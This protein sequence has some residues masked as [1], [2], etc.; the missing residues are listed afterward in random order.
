MSG[1]T[2]GL[3]SFAFSAATS[4]RTGAL[5][6]LGK[7]IPVTQF[8]DLLSASLVYAGPS[9]GTNSVGLLVNAEA[10]QAWTASSG[11][12]WLR[13]GVTNGT[14][15]ATVSFTFD[16][17]PGGVRIGTLTIAGQTLTLIQEALSL[18]VTNRVEGPAAGTDSV[19]LAS[20]D[21]PWTATANAPWLHLSPANQSGTGSTNVIFSFDANSG[22]TRVGTLTIAGLT[23]TVTQGGST[24]VRVPLQLTSLISSGLSGPYGVAVDGG[25]D[26]YIGDYYN[27]AVKEWLPGNGSVVTLPLSAVTGPIGVAV[28]AAG[29]IYLADSGTNAIEEWMP[30]NNTTVALVTNGLNGPFGVA[31]DNVGNVYIADTYNNAIKEWS[32]FS[33]AV[34]LLATN[35]LNTP[36]GIALDAAGNVYIADTGNNAIEEWSSANG[37]FTTLVS[38]GLNGPDAV[39]VDGGGNVY[40]ASSGDNTLKEWSFASGTVTT[41]VSSGLN[42]PSGVAVDAAGNVYIADTSDSATKEVVRAF[43]DPTTRLETTNAGSDVLPMILPASE[44]LLAPFA[45][46]SEQSWLTITGVTNGVVGFAFTA[47]AT[48][49]TAQISVLGQSITVNQFNDLL[50]SNLIYVGPAAGTNS[51]ALTV[52]PIAP[53]NWTAASQA[54]WLR[55]GVTNGTGGATVSFTFDANPGGVRIGTLTI[56]GQT[57]TLIQEA[58]SLGVTNRVEG[59]AAGTDSVV[60]ASLD[61]PWTATANAPWL[62]LSPANQS[63]T[64]STNVIFSFDANSGA[65]RVGTLTIAGLTL[66]VTQGGS[67]YV[68][69]PLQL[70]SLISS[71]LSGPYGVA[72]DGGGDVYIGDYYNN[73]V[74]EWLPGN[75]SVVTLPLSAVTG[76]IGVAV[77][78]AGDIYLADSGTNA[79]EEWMPSNNTTMALVTNGLNGPF[80]VAVDNVGNVYI[81]DTYNNAIKEWSPFSGAVTLLATNGLNTPEG[82][83]LDAAGNVYIADTGNN[84][85]E[86]WSSA[87]GSFTTLVSS[88]LNGP[89]AVAVDGGG[90]VY[91]ASSGDNT[92]KEWSFASG[93]VTTLVSS[94]L[95]NPS[96][97]AVDAAGNVYLGDSG[98]NAVKELPYALLDPTPKRKGT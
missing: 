14:G 35:G 59:P 45:P 43:V 96:G 97:V 89:D 17:N 90:N 56:A 13:L 61:T 57:L 33:G 40:I 84:A 44:D 28:D 2:N 68:R 25:G 23:L 24:Y 7:T 47:T 16:A 1:I 73:A 80:G 81:A 75:G 32:P 98:D 77:D 29:D 3:V 49:R 19:V 82:I 74:K 92:L 8:S 18:G 91:I 37:S 72:V 34:T 93:T 65:T 67:T 38:S 69:V 5:S 9:G 10:A 64:G 42:N 41:L 70:T 54:T 66:T 6:L 85:I 11:A 55:L 48:N 60:L 20:L 62:H 71:G 53:Q 58:L 51:V 31:V 87:N 30:S 4:N 15:G 95:N 78:A 83:A 88:G 63:G 39:A 94:G 21:T 26:V 86:E 27:N 50:N 79:I 12:P 46:A 76:P 36:E 22:A 52:D